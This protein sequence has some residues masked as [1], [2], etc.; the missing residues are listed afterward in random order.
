MRVVSGSILDVAVDLRK[1]S[2]TFG[3]HVSAK[4]SADEWN[5]ILL[6]IR[7]GHG[8][9]T[10]EPQTQLIYKVTNF[11]SPENDRGVRWDDPDLGIDWPFKP[12]ELTL[13]DKDKN[14]PLF[15]DIIDRLPF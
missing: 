4:I 8:I 1:G 10:L 11:Y 6:P 2:S 13:S 12:E 3:K 5:Q 7:F 14:Q 9:V 15:K